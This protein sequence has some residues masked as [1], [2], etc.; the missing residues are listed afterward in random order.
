[1]V[2][3]CACVRACVAGD[4]LASLLAGCMDSDNKRLTR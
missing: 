4:P 3:V 1:V 2:S